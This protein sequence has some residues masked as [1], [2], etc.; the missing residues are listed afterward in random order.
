MLFFTSNQPVGLTF[1]PYPPFGLVT[2][3]FI[4]PA[5]DLILVGIYTVALSVSND[6]ECTT[7]NKEITAE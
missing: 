6:T 5:S 4:A 7:Y 3:C 1:L 2:I